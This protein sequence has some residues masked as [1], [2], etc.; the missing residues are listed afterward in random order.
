[1][2]FSSE[3]M[4]AGREHRDKF[5]V[6]EGKKNYQSKAFV[7]HFKASVIKHKAN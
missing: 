3:T 1:M 7:S 2:D 4:E 5:Q 6:L